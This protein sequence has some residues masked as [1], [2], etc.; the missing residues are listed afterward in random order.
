M[1]KIVTIP[2]SVLTSRTKKVEQFDG[3]LQ[4]L[5]KDM[6]QTL[7]AQVNP[8]GVGLAAS[9]VGFDLA[10]F[11]IRPSPNAKTEVFVNPKIIKVEA[12]ILEDSGKRVKN[13][14]GSKNKKKKHRLEGGLSIPKILGPTI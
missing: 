11:I 4:R 12:G 5:V 8:Q 1:L 6:D 3:S 2:N 14:Q 10:V 13:P 9:Q 7:K